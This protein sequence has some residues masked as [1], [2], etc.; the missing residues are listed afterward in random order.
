MAD[1]AV[2]VQSEIAAAVGQWMVFTLAWRAGRIGRRAGVAERHGRSSVLMLVLMVAEVHFSHHGFV[3]AVRG[4]ERPTPLEGQEHQQKGG[5]GF[6]HG[7]KFKWGGRVCGSWAPDKT[8]VLRG[9]CPAVPD[10]NARFGQTGAEAPRMSSTPCVNRP[11][12]QLGA[13]CALAESRCAC[14]R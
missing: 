11:S 12:S 7:L 4:R 1:A 9:A 13:R 2:G 3:L 10:L 8:R 5:Y 6:A 14:R